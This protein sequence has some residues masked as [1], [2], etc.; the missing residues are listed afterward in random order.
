MSKMANLQLSWTAVVGQ[1]ID[2]TGVPEG[3]Y[4]VRVTLNKGIPKG[5]KPNPIFDEGLNLYS[6]VSEVRIKVP[7]PR[8]KVAIVQ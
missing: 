4:I 2:I 3:E 8:K 1:W 5:N 6:N 7:D